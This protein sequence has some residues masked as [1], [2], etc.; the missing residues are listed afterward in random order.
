MITRCLLLSG[1]LGVV[2][3][4]QPA[5]LSESDGGGVFNG[6]SYLY[7]G[8]PGGG[9]AQGVLFVVKGRNLGPCETK[10]AT[11]FPLLN[12][13]DGVSMKITVGGVAKDAIMYYVATC[14]GGSRPDQ[15]AAILPSTTPIGDG[16]I[17]V[18]VGAQTSAPFPISV[19]K[20][21][22]GIFTRDST[23]AGPA[24]VYNAVTGSQTMPTQPA[25]PGDFMVVMGTGLGA[26][27]YDETMAAPA[28]P[29]NLVPDLEVWV[30]GI[31]AQMQYNN[32]MSQCCTGVDQINFMVPSGIEGCYVPLVLKSGN[33]VSNFTTMAIAS[34][35]SACTD[36]IGV[37]AADLQSWT[38][39]TSVTVGGVSLTRTSIHLSLPAGVVLPPGISL[40]TTSDSGGA[41]FYKF[42]PTGLANVAN[43]FN[44]FDFGSCR[45][46][47]IGGGSTTPNTLPS[48]NFLDAGAAITVTGPNGQKQL[49][50]SSTPTNYYSA[51]LGSGTSLFLDA[52]N[53][54]IAGPGGTDIGSFSTS[55]TI[56]T[57]LTWTNRDTITSVDRTKNQ[58][59]TW[60]GGDPNS[61]VYIFGMSLAANS[62]AM[63][64][65]TER[66]SAGQFSIPSIVLLALPP[67]QVTEGVATGALAVSS[68]TQ[69]K[70]FTAAGCD[71][72][73]V[74]HSS[75]S[76][77]SVNYQ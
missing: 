32:R 7:S 34:Q 43:P 62:G 70:R 16:T 56:P 73:S 51:Q 67:S 2:A 71:L 11:T 8:L 55:Y 14:L 46:I 31:K 26:A 25:R 44:S 76:Q 13:I 63:F 39:K 24:W 47:F 12:S 15:L 23:G 10:V 9:I 18:T 29:N 60:T 53:Y 74:S 64:F 35:G 45:V 69:A 20:S 41:S 52:G 28:N 54:T 4:A 6:A 50:K 77:I 42:D 1:I 19:V 75:G 59:I 17:T 65:C 66:V 21:A 72:C 58:L 30:G 37:T 3:F 61:Y 5:I 38:G 57:S 48:F 49:P 27:N 33:K 40:D 22:V 68:S 36:S